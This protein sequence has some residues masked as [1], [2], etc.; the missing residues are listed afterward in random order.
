MKLTIPAAA[1]SAALMPAILFNLTLPRLL[2]VEEKK[3][4]K[5]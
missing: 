4:G 2:Q 1:L 5:T 3:G